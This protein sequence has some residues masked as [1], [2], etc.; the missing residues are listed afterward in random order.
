MEKR[1]M[2]GKTSIMK[3]PEFVVL[4]KSLVIGLLLAEVW[5]IGC[6]IGSLY[7]VSIASLGHWQRLI[8]TALVLLLCMYYFFKR[9]GLKTAIKIIKSLRFDLASAFC[10]GIYMHILA[11]PTMEQFHLRIFASASSLVPTIILILLVL[12]LS[13][14][15][16]HQWAKKSNTVQKNHFISDIEIREGADDLFDINERA[17]NFAKSV[18]QS[19]DVFGVDGP[20]G[21]GKTSFINL[22]ELVWSKN[23]EF[24]VCRFEPLRY[25]SQPDLT[26]RLV[27]ELTSTIQNSV[28]APEFRLA[29][30]RYSRLIRGKAEVTFFGFKLSLEPSSETVDDLLNDIDEVLKQVNR[31]VII[32]IDDL[33][34]LDAKTVNN[35][36]FAT[37]RTLKLTQATYVLCYDTEVLAGGQEENSRAREFLEKF[38][39]IKFSL[40]MDISK[41]C[42]FLRRKWKN[43]VLQDGS[44]P[45]DAIT[46]LSRIFDELADI[47][48]SDKASHYLPLVG[49]MRKVKRFINTIRLMQIER[50]NLGRTDF[51]N[52]DLINL[53]LLHL[54]YPGLFRQ[55]YA[56]ET[57]GNIGSFSAKYSSKSQK[58]E[59]SDNFKKLIESSKDISATFLVKQLFDTETLDCFSYHKPDKNDFAARACFNDSSFRTLEAYLKL[60]VRVETPEPQTTLVLYKE[61]LD[62]IRNGTA[63]TTI[64]AGSD[65]IS[66]N[67]ELAHERLWIEILNQSYNFSASKV[68]EAINTLVDFL[69]RYPSV[70][71]DERGLRD[72]SIYTL[73]QLLDRA[74]WGA[75]PESKRRDS[76][77]VVE[78]AW[79]IF[80]ENKYSD[81]GL[82][83]RLVADKQG[84]I[85]WFDLLIFRLECSVDRQGQIH[86]LLSALIRHQDPDAETTGGVDKLA[87]IEMRIIS[88]KIFEL[89][90]STYIM[91]K[92]NFITDVNLTHDDAFLGSIKC[93]LEGSDFS[94][95]V[96]QQMRMNIAKKILIK[97]SEVKSF[98]LYQLSNSS[99]PLGSGVGCGFYDEDGN[100]DDKGI[101]KAMNDYMF[102]VCFN[103][104]VDEQNAL[105]FFDHCLSHLT[106][107]FYSGDAERGL[108]ASKDSIAGGLDPMAMG[109]FWIKHNDLIRQLLQSA[110]TREVHTSNYTVKYAEIMNKVFPTLDDMAEDASKGSKVTL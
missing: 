81:K 74:G 65:F 103:P 48:E 39:T 69:P 28:Y 97:R 63:I 88:Q 57:A 14:I 60:I 62:K 1:L 59:N 83:N 84:T 40:F 18:M 33:D 55:I 46:R 106:T 29:A 70:A 47:L 9:G 107:P 66:E 85:G 6:S 11:Y 56:E 45:P 68:D 44:T 31:R 82:L 8:G 98:T 72:T 94:D 104:T 105:H 79:R 101:A 67:W 51:N 24:L 96:S 61:A 91:P 23:S 3:M 42:E 73:L 7:A 109:H 13:P 110:Q 32:V 2:S 27:Q 86:N 100:A 4:F 26:D 19:R 54:N 15:L 22:A 76:L 108:V 20:W 49:N 34:R 95:L 71:S 10:I 80:G 90:R 16:R 89:F 77:S 25:A 64:L 38:V 17:S 37:K 41:I 53:I 50:T 99:S 58:F 5:I 21:I 35:I 30:N 75:G 43:S 52:S 92:K 102:D 12:L 87:V 93:Q 78:V 36:L